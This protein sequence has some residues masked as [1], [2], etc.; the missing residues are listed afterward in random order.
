MA[1]IA[2]RMSWVV[3]YKLFCPIGTPH[4]PYEGKCSVPEHAST[5]S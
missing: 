4:F 2:Y 5:G 1:A 3:S